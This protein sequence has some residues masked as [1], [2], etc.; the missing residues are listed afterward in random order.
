MSTPAPIES[1]TR[2]ASVPPEFAPY[3][4]PALAEVNVPAYVLDRDGRCRWLN[5][6][7]MAIAGDVVGR[8]LTEIV[9]ADAQT[10][11]N[12]FQRRLA[13]LE[14]RDH[15]VALVARDGTRTRVDISSVP[16]ESGHRVVGMFGLAIPVDRKRVPPRDS[17]L[18]PRQ[19]E[20]LE[21]LADGMSTTGIA[22]KLF[23]SEQTV[24]NHVREILRRLGASSRLA[25][26]ATARRLGLI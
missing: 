22:Q 21:L 7:A 18:T 9:D 11:R 6:A 17:P 10:A 16:L 19:Q 24:R 2:A 8:P 13:G 15:S 26:V 5:P 25:A 23:L 14:E 3:L 20:V 12:V 1:T 4:P